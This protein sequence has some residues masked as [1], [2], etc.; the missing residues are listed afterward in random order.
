[1]AL[2]AHRASQP[3]QME[4]SRPL[5]PTVD[6]DYLALPRATAAARDFERFIMKT[7]FSLLH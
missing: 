7:N 4:L 6:V 3:A 5:W 1:M 2:T